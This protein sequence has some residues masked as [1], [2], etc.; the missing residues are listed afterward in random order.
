MKIIFSLLTTREESWSK[1]GSSF[2]R[3]TPL[4]EQ[5]KSDHIFHKLSEVRLDSIESLI[6]KPL[7]LTRLT[8]DRK[9]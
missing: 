9:I 1:S 4:F 2:F 7:C 6:F 5:P 8:S 3:K